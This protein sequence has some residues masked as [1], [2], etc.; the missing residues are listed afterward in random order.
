MVHSI[1]YIAIWYNFA[2][3]AVVWF[4]PKKVT[5]NAFVFDRTGFVFMGNP[6]FCG[7]IYR[8]YIIGYTI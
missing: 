6:I 1:W 2:N 5:E 4:H 7:I 3:S 8:A